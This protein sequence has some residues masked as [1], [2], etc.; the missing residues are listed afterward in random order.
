MIF[1]QMVGV[2]IE[3]AAHLPSTVSV[4][5]SGEASGEAPVPT[6]VALADA[7]DRLLPGQELVGLLDGLEPADLHEA[8]VVEAIAGW[9][10][11]TSWVAAR[12]ARMITELARRRE[13]GRLGEFVAD[14]VAA[15]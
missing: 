2:L 4:E 10:R 7:L 6:G 11:I 12:Q 8:A 15:R 14:E 9:E 1:R 3:G 13:L 5:V